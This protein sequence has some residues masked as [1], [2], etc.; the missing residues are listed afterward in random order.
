MFKLPATTKATY[1]DDLADGRWAVK[2]NRI[3][4][5]DGYTCQCCGSTNRSL[6]V[7]HLVYTGKP[8]EAPDHHLETLC[9]ACHD[10]RSRTVKGLKEMRTADLRSLFHG[11]G[12]LAARRIVDD[13]GD[14][15]AM[16]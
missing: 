14:I 8:W 5:R 6:E 1:A 9:H 2:R 7:N 11:R 16:R 13:I 4:E 10:W 15:G 3:L 12:Y